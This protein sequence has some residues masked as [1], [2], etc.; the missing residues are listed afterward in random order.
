MFLSTRSNF[1]FVYFLGRM[2][3]GV[4]APAVATAVTL[5]TADIETTRL[6]I[7]GEGIEVRMVVSL[8]DVAEVG[9]I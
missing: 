9:M 5:M 7:V 4:A 8:G 1:I 6:M 3:T 2:M